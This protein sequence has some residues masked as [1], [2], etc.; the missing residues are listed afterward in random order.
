MFTCFLLFCSRFLISA[1][2][3]FACFWLYVLHIQLYP[4]RYFLWACFEYMYIFLNKKCFCSNHTQ[5]LC[6]HHY[7]N[8]E[9]HPQNITGSMPNLYSTKKHMQLF[10]NKRNICN[11]LLRDL[12]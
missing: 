4:F 10:K 12:K 8:T 7:W 3:E 5:N 9:V 6:F 1:G 2:S 11:C